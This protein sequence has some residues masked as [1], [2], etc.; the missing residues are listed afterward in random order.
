MLYTVIIV[1][2]KIEHTKDAYIF[3]CSFMSRLVCAGCT[4]THVT[5]SARDGRI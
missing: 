4:R 1:L 3:V 2:H 5:V